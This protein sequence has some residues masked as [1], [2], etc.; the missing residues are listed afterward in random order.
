MSGR[1]GAEVTQAEAL[2][3]VL[4]RESEA[5]ALGDVPA[6]QRRRILSG[7]RWT[8]WL[9]ALAVPFSVGSNLV[10]ARVG[11]EMLGVYGVL[12]VYVGLIASFLYFGGD[13]VVIRFIPD[14]RE[15]ERASF[16]VSYLGVILAVLSGCLVVV[17]CSPVG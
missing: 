3:G 8:V 11:P 5:T 7:M 12:S 17:Y 6:H 1:G 16:L 2:T 14:C 4:D 9:S 15:G 13:T 10:L